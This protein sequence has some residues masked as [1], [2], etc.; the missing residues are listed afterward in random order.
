MGGVSSQ[1]G[2][3]P[4]GRCSKRRQRYGGAASRC[5]LGA[6][7]GGPLPFRACH[8]SRRRAGVA[9]SGPSHRRR[10]TQSASSDERESS[11][12][13]KVVGDDDR[14][15]T[16]SRQSHR[17]EVTQRTRHARKPL[18]AR[19]LAH[20]AKAKRAMTSRT[21]HHAAGPNQRK[22]TRALPSALQRR[23]QEALQRSLAGD[24]SEVICR[25]MGCAKSW[26]YKWKN[27]YQVTEP[28]WFQEHARRPETTPTQ[29]PDALEADI[30]RRRHT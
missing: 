12:G 28:A 17:G 7:G 6:G 27:R 30:V 9:S 20:S 18:E 2:S 3:S 23:R 22:E 11:H 14:H 5:G 19:G 25:E 8:A 24:P 4:R 1:P 15:A 21:K 29:T 10:K 26:L 16:G 13:E